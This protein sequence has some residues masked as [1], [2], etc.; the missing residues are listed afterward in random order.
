MPFY[1]LT[2][3]F[4][5]VGPP[6][7][8]FSESWDFL[9]LDDDQAVQQAMSFPKERASILSVD[10]SIVA[11]RLSR[12]AIATAD[13]CK[14]R[15]DL[16]RVPL[17]L[18]AVKGRDDGDADTPWA[19]ILVSIPTKQSTPSVPDQPRPRQWQCRGIPDDWWKTAKFTIPP[20]AKTAVAQFTTYL[21]KQLQAGH[22]KANAG[23][24]QL[25]IQ[26]FLP[27]CIKRIS[28]R[29]IGRPFGLLRGAQSRQTT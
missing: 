23:C 11:V 15:A 20:A 10:W 22:V 3:L 8:G 1:R 4:D 7:C 17:C 25:N 6:P 2:A 14:I 24:L 29:R 21:A 26:P 18:Q 12:L 27:G 28:N 16:L 5:F 19:A 13:P 9:A